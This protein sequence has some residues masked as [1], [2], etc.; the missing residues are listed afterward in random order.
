MLPD[1]TTLPDPRVYA[2]HAPAEARALYELASASLGADT[3]ERSDALDATLRASLS[4]LLANDDGRLAAT[5]ADAPSAAIARHLW[6]LLEAAWREGAG[7]EHDTLALTVFALP[8]VL[9]VGAEGGSDEGALSGI[10]DEPERCAAILAQFGALRQNA[11]VVFAGVLAS[12]D[13]IDIARLPSI[14]SWRRLAVAGDLPAVAPSLDVA[15]VPIAFHRGR[16]S[17]HLRF[18]LGSALARPG[19]DLLAGSDVGGWAVPLSQELARQLAAPGVTVLALPRAPR[20]LLP[21]AAEGR[22][23]QREVSA[24]I[25]ASNALRALRAT[26]GEPTAV[27]SAHRSPD[28]PGGGELRLSLSSPFSQ[29]NA[30]GFRCPLY[31][32]ERVADVAAMLVDLLR[33]CRVADV[34]VLAGIHAD[35]VA[36]TG[37]PLLLKPDTIPDPIPQGAA[38]PLH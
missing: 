22:A 23:A 15:P 3:S 2:E 37:L 1:V 20:H 5:L 4:S 29:R 17:V 24:Q 25:F 11:T 8:I 27:I 9:V 21:A 35:R 32:T 26:V 18:L 13:A 30:E 34:R 12:A 14:H 10:L 33:D 36:G 31:P 38:T 7:A 6:R 19:A 28:A 16:E